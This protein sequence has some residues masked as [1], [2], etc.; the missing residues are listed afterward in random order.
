MK[1]TIMILFVLAGC[2]VPG[3]LGAEQ[4]AARKFDW[5]LE[6]YP[7]IEYRGRAFTF[8][9]EFTWP[10]GFHRVDSASLTPF[11]FWVSNMPLWDFTKGIF[12]YT[13]GTK[14]KS[15]EISRP[16]HFP[17]RTSHFTDC[18]IPLQL[19][20][21]YKFWRG[22]QDE[23][24]LIPLRGD[25]L[26]YETFLKS[27][28]TYDAPMS[29]RFKPTQKREPAESEFNAF[30]DLCAICTD[31]ETLEQNSDR[32]SDTIL[33]PGDLYVGRDS[34]G[35]KGKV[36]VVMV[37]TNN[38]KGEYR[39]IVATGCSERCDFYIPLFH[40]DRKNPWLTFDEIKGLI[41]DQPITGFFRVKWIGKP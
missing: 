6:Q 16:V 9:S 22:R 4:V 40:N 27:E 3:V 2:V 33:R 7:Y 1:L 35:L 41:A 20:A 36:Y 19:V 11:Q 5:Y 24:K 26:T 31:Y 39:Y 17:W 37:A 12:S 28:V 14:F 29:V 30:F 34:T 32:V 23:V 25:T 38:D 15:S 13:S 10:D 18:V 8:E 21:D